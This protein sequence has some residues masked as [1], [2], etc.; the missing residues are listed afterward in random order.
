MRSKSKLQ[1]F[2]SLD[3]QDLKTGDVLGSLIEN[4]IDEGMVVLII[5]TRSYMLFEKYRYK[6][7]HL[8]SG[9]GFKAYGITRNEDIAKG[10]AFLKSAT[11]HYYVFHV[12]VGPPALANSIL[13]QRQYQNDLGWPKT[14]ESLV[15]G[16]MEPVDDELI[17]Y[18]T[19]P[20]KGIVLAQPDVKPM[21]S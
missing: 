8:T 18:G 15:V 12:L 14:V 7:I 21:E 4:L 9:D 1:P 2:A 16:T 3:G 17:C 10:V 19:E 6:Q 5:K 13:S 20:F 11:W